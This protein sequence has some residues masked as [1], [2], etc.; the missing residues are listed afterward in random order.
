MVLINEMIFYV[1]S[2]N[3]PLQAVQAELDYLMMYL[4]NMDF[5]VLDW[6]QCNLGGLANLS[7]LQFSLP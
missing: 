7:D 3:K 1:L 6:Q 2:W 5:A 4:K